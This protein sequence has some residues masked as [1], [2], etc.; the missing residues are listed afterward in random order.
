MLVFATDSP[1][2]SGIWKTLKG[3]SRVYLGNTDPPPADGSFDYVRYTSG[4]I[5]GGWAY[6]NCFV[7]S[8]AIFMGGCTWDGSRWWGYA[9]A[10]Y[11]L[12]SSYPADGLY[13][14]K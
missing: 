9:G 2:Q 10:W 6:P 4:Y 14:I 7:L 1:C 5:A 3:I 8:Q 11:S 12:G 13:L